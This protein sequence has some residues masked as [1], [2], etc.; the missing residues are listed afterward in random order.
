MLIANRIITG[1]QI[2]AKAF[3][4]FAL[5]RILYFKCSRICPG[6]YLRINITSNR[7][8]IQKSSGVRIQPS[9]Y[10]GQENQLN[11]R[12]TSIIQQR[13]NSGHESCICRIWNSQ[14]VRILHGVRSTMRYCSRH[15]CITFSQIKENDARNQLSFDWQLFI[16]GSE[17]NISLPVFNYSAEENFILRLKNKLTTPPPIALSPLQFQLRS[18]RKSSSDRYLHHPSPLSW[19]GNKT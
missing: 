18:N 8:Q 5:R 6:R 17:Y 3:F 2:I 12:S 19:L 14:L 13:T 11:R 4:I 7:R 15:S 10:P 9:R 1:K 16:S